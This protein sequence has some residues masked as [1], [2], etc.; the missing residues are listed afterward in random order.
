[1]TAH[2]GTGPTSTQRAAESRRLTF[3]S[4]S[5]CQPG[6]RQRPALTPLAL[7]AVSAACARRSCLIVDRFDR[8]LAQLSGGVKL[9][10][11]A[12]T[13]GVRACTRQTQAALCQPCSLCHCLALIAASSL[14]SRYCLPARLCALQR[15]VTEYTCAMQSRKHVCCNTSCSHVPCYVARAALIALAPLT[16]RLYFA[17]R[18]ALMALTTLS[19]RFF[20][21]FAS[22][23]LCR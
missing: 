18:S 16:L 10:S 3:I 23:S 21:A 8:E 13:G 2:C 5:T 15:P 7:S 19:L 17:A 4:I 14:S 11:R 9:S 12:F 6:A 22:S 1:M 20:S